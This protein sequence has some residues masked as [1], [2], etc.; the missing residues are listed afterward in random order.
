MSDELTTWVQTPPIPIFFGGRG[1]NCSIIIIRSDLAYQFKSRINACNRCMGIIMI[2]LACEK[3]L[4]TC[5]ITAR[6]SI[7]YQPIIRPVNILFTRNFL[8]ICE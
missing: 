5:R 2:P 4:K 8:K 3:Q 1:L 6:R 7:N